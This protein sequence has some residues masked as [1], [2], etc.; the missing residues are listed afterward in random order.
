M[1]AAPACPQD[2]RRAA[3]RVRWCCRLAAVLLCGLHAY[4]ARHT[5][6]PDG[7]SYLDLA[8]G[9]AHGSLSAS[10]NAYW[11]PLY[12]WLLAAALSVARPTAYWECAVAHGLNFVI[13]LGALAAFEW[14]LTQ[15]LRGLPAPE[16]DRPGPLP[17]WALVGLAYALFVWMARRLV[18]VSVV[19]PDMCVAALVFL[20]AGLLLHIRRLGP[21]PG[22]S[23][24]LG[25]VLAAAYLAKAVMFPLG[26]V[27]LGVSALAAGGARRAV[28]HLAAAGLAFGLVAGGYAAALS[29]ARGHVTFGD[30]G[31]LNYA[32]Y[33]GGVPRP[34]AS[35]ADGLAHPPR[36]LDG[37]VAV[38]E[39][40]GPA[41]GTYPLWYD[42]AYWYEGVA[43][44][45]GL[46]PQAAA[47]ARTA[48]EYFV[49]LGEQL[50]A[51]TAVVGVLL[52]FGLFAR[53]G[54][55]R[56]RLGQGLGLLAGQ[57]PILLPAAAAVAAYALVGHVE[58]RLIGPFLVLLAAALLAVVRVAA[59]QAQAAAYLAR[60]CLWVLAALLGI[61]VL[62]DTSQAAAALA[63]GEGPRAHSDWRVAH[64]LR[65]QG[66]RE[67]D[68]VGFV[69][70]TFDA[71]WA[72][73]ARLHIVAEVPQPE[74]PRFWAAGDS[75]QAEALGALG[76]AGSRAVVA[77]RPG[78][79]P[80][81]WQAIPGTDYAYRPL[82]DAGAS[83]LARRAVHAA[84]PD[85]P[86][87]SR[88][89]VKPP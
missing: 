77:R 71:Y 85:G 80:P 69:G 35:A 20:A 25:L 47:L 53:T 70:F 89:E 88:K 11:S 27:F 6:N 37:P 74:A 86:D 76:S 84:G 29:A 9:I 38:Y 54:P 81:G 28:G 56:S 57:Y 36:R 31:K 72:R 52:L 60:A 3:R 51:F 1:N 59:A 44:R 15:W 65:R 40:A 17:E 67:G 14:F 82:A 33:V 61:N 18:T 7:V 22:R 83:L 49:L 55:W 68:P 62:F 58:G 21:T 30:S 32:W 79:A 78:G 45:W 4:A 2:S 63:S 19:S 13:F 16:E 26:L 87:G 46:R 24:A 64:F 75:V 42:P 34:H 23:A 12:P 39:V 41:G 43:V 10:L 66:L 5:M 73:L 8:D 48:A 50:L